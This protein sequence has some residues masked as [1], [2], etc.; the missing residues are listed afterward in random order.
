MMR[1]ALLIAALG[2]GCTLVTN[3]DPSRTA[4]VTDKLCADGLDNDGDGLRDC[5]DWDCLDKK[6]CCTLEAVVFQ[7]RF[8]S[9]TCVA[10]DAALWDS[11]GQPVPTVCGGI[12]KPN[13]AEQ[14]YDVGVLGRTRV[15]LHPGLAATVHVSGRPEQ[16]GRLVI[17]FTMQDKIVGGMTGCAPVT[18]VNAFAEARLQRSANGVQ[19]VARFEGRDL[20]TS[21]ELDGDASHEI[22]LAIGADR[23]MAFTVDQKLLAASD[24]LPAV[25]GA[26]LVLFG[27]GEVAGYEDVRVTDGTQCDDP[28]AWQPAPKFEVLSGIPDNGGTWDSFQVFAPAILSTAGAGEQLLYS[29]CSMGTSSNRCLTGV[30]FGRAAVAGDGRL[31]RD[32]LNPLQFDV[33]RNNVDVSLLRQDPAPAL[34]RGYLTGADV[35]SSFTF[36][37]QTFT[38]GGPGT[39]MELG[40]ILLYVGNP[41][42]WDDGAICCASA[43]QLDGQI[44]MWYAGQRK[45]DP[46][47]RVGLATSFDGATFLRQVGNPVLREGGGDEFDGRGVTEPEVLWDSARGLYRM[48]YTANGFLGTTS[49]AYAVSTDGVHWHK[50]PGNPVVPH[51]AVGLDVIGGPAVRPDLNGLKMWATGAQNGSIG[52]RIFSLENRGKPSVEPP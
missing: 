48:W 22:R 6:P 13:K 19:V 16:A 5:Q 30:G 42:E 44:R 31:M 36:F 37:I 38:V 51:S 45:N 47:W 43:V 32:P 1:A 10:P 8:D 40:Q 41:G 17:G 26:R 12:L 15:S 35:V 7:D 2:A 3:F 29:G 27:R 14:C 18:P 28:G 4:E 52:L 11:W 20:A 49:V 50:Y 23:R 24:P 46:T 21:A 34:A 39:P 33:S 9:T 25:V